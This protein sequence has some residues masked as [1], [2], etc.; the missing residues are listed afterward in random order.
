VVAEM[1]QGWKK[2]NT[3]VAAEMLQQREEV[4]M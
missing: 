2:E 4:T 1:V 3:V